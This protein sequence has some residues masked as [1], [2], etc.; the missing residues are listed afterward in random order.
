M[1]ATSSIVHH[2]SQRL[3]Q[4]RRRQNRTDLLANILIFCSGVF[5]VITLIILAEALFDYSS[6]VRT[7]LFFCF[8]LFFLGLGGWI[9]FRPFFRWLDLLSSQTEVQIAKHIGE[10]FPS[11]KDR[12]VNALQ[13]AHDTTAPTFFSAELL[14]ES[15]KNFSQEIQ[16]LDFTQSV[17][18]SH[19]PRYLRWLA[20]SAGCFMILL[21]VFPSS[22]SG[23]AYRLIH[24]T[25]EFTP[26]PRYRIEVQ[27]GNKEIVKGENVSVRVRVT[28]LL[29][30]FSSR[31]NDLTIFR[32]QEGQNNYDEVKIESDS[33]GLFSTS[34]QAVRTTTKYFVQ[35]ADAESDHY[36]LTVLD[37]PLIRS[38]RVR[39]DYPA[40]TKIPP[41]FLDEFVGDVTALTGTRIFL[42]GESSKPL[43]AAEIRF[44]DKTSLMLTKQG[45]KFS[46]SFSLL[47]DDSYFIT[48][49]DAEGLSNIEPVHYRLKAV[50][51][52][53][54]TITIVEPGRNIDIAGD[55]SITLFL[56]AK[57]DFGFSSM[58]LG[59]RL[60]KSR[61]EQA[62]TDYTF[63]PIPLSGTT[64]GQI[65]LSYAWNLSSLHLVPEDVMEYFAE[66]FDNDGIK[67]PK[68]GR[69]PL[70]LLRLPSLDE[71]F[72]DV[73]KEHERSLEDLQ[74]SLDETKKL[75][76]DIESINRDLKKNKD[77]DW[78]TQ[79]KMEEM[80]KRYQEVQKKIDNVQSRIE[81]MTEQMQQQNVLSK[82]TMDK[83]MELQ[84]LF[85]QLDATELQKILSQLQQKT[86]NISKEQ[87]Q[88]TIQ[89]MTFS[90][91]RFRQSIE[92]TLNLLKR[93]QIEQ[94]IDEVKKRSQEIEKAEKELQEESS[95]PS[96]DSQKQQEMAKKQDDLARQEQ[97][98]E[99]EAADLQNKM[100][101]FFT[102]MPAER[103]QKSLDQLQK[104]QVNQKMQQT[105]QQLRMGRM[106]SAQQMQQQIGE[107]VRQFSEQM[108]AMQQEMLR[109]QSQYVINEMRKAVKNILEISKDEESL[110]QQSQEAPQNSPQLRQNAQD[111]QRAAQDL[112]NVIKELSELSQKSFVVTPE[113]GKAI[114][115]ALAR[116]NS[117]MRA[118]DLRNGSIASQ[119][120]GQ[121]MAALNRAAM[122]VQ[123]ALQAMMQGNSGGGAGSLLQ[124]LQMMAGQQMSVNMQTQQLGGELSPQQAEEASRLAK[125]Q[126]AIQ[127][128]LE[129]L[130]REAQ[131]ST[132]QK[133]ILGDLQKIAEEMNEVVKNLEQNNVNPETVKKQ[134]RILS[135]LLDA[136]KS[137]RERDYEKRRK[138]ETGTPV[139]RRSPKD[140]DWN[141]LENKS[142]L[143]EE[144][145]KALEQG[146][147]K[148]YQE[149]IRKY[150]EEL[151]KT[152]K[153]VY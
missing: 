26:P 77:P 144:L 105:S 120:Q 91:E 132:D 98:L 10:F 100:E 94:K 107:Q 50:S 67:G 87:L 111:Q 30:A 153:S 61:Y 152:E 59:Y 25:Q 75:K 139:T 83:Y 89:T 78:Q 96:V 133:Q 108:N 109:Q 115:E 141:S 39:L 81:K 27:P 103:M 118:L 123:S 62:Q 150:F 74:Q 143:R 104:Q 17:N 136:S 124:Q 76:E 3:A 49:T 47:S 35:F 14:G 114:G 36:T 135:R 127:K 55:Q 21:L 110:K 57:D 119:E 117:A 65:E 142:Q 79:K 51:D 29:P 64:E 13:L 113:M 126:G 12:L 145:L 146:Y 85:Q 121:A 149:L 42:S 16:N 23:A 151:E 20:M 4:V 130:N 86:P 28:S 8:M 19:L 53:Y 129:Q 88:Q 1:Q 46:A 97:A 138:A 131:Q 66:V 33:V 43:Q 128:S 44:G 70:F 6:T 2:L 9:I 18:T 34:F 82:E 32:Q 73:D 140:L 116:M 102:E 137:A 99:R 125:E 106:Q 122:Q 15:L 52:E 5:V 90:E 72:A 84:Q 22:I 37:R 63:T 71:V 45:E 38:F 56:R 41:K 31:S 11:I 92:R 134:E 148:D 7:I 80:A 24:C 101:E 40:Y 93:L 112:N 95:K 58:R 68:S 147:S 69:S 60:L 54:P 48:V